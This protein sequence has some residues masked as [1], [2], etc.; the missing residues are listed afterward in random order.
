M[1]V[2]RSDDHQYLSSA[3][4]I[5]QIARNQGQSSAT[6]AHTG[7]FDEWQRSQRSDLRR[8]TVVQA[9][10]ASDRPQMCGSSLPPVASTDY[11]D[12]SMKL[13]AQ[14]LY[15]SRRGNPQAAPSWRWHNPVSAQ[16]S[17]SQE[18]VVVSPSK[19]ITSQIRWTSSNANP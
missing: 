13:V 8:I 17:Q 6:R 7:Q 1:S 2:S 10:I 11:G 15:L 5:A 18:D 19:S 9:H 16:T 12:L 3:H 4:S 14:L